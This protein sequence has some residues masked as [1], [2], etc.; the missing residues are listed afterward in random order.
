MTAPRGARYA[1]RLNY[2]PAAVTWG[3]RRGWAC[4]AVK[5]EWYR[6]VSR[7]GPRQLW[8]FGFPPPGHP[9][10]TPQTLAGPATLLR[11]AAALGQPLHITIDHPA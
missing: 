11:V 1:M 8:V 10:W 4:A 9:Y 3:Q 6:F 5:E 7:A 2:R